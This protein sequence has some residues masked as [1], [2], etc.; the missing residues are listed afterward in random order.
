[1]AVV[2]G[3]TQLKR[4]LHY[5]FSLGS[6]SDIP[7]DGRAGHGRRAAKALGRVWFVRFARP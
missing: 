6:R 1:M 4:L 2:M 7:R 3:G 5:R